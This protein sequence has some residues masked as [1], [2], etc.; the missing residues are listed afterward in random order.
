LRGRISGVN[1]A[2]G[3]AGLGIGRGSN[4]ASVDDDDIG[5][6]PVERRNASTLSQL[7]L[8]CRTIGLRGATTELFDMKCFHDL[9]E[10]EKLLL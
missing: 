3:I 8:N 9:A 10:T 6:I 5:D 4:S 1:F 7:I 2:Y